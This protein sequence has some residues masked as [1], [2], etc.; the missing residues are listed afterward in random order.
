MSVPKTKSDKTAS[1][2]TDITDEILA[3][4]REGVV[5]ELIMHTRRDVLEQEHKDK[6]DQLYEEMKDLPET[7]LDDFSPQG[8]RRHLEKLKAKIIEICIENKL[9]IK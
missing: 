9:F 1:Y 4:K 7:Q 5:K 3:L 6:L 8:R 2:T